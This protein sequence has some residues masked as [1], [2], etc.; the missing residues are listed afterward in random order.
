MVPVPLEL[1]GIEFSNG[2]DAREGLE[3]IRGV[4]TR[5]PDVL[6]DAQQVELVKFHDAAEFHRHSGDARQIAGSYSASPVA[7]ANDA[8]M[9]W[10]IYEE[11]K[12]GNYLVVYRLQPLGEVTGENIVFLDV[13]TNGNTIA[14]ERTG[15]R[16]IFSRP[17]E[18]CAR[19]THVE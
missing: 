6:K 12:P 19:F 14:G 7:G 3:L 17:L 2:T 15:R 5:Y 16:S 8:I 1:S 9:F 10:G 13:C 11:W 18:R 4:Y